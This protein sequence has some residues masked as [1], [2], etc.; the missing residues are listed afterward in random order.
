[1]RIPLLDF[2]PDGLAAASIVV[3]G[4]NRKGNEPRMA[5]RGLSRNQKRRRTTV[6]RK[7]AKTQMTEGIFPLVLASLRLCVRPLRRRV[8]QQSRQRQT[9]RTKIFAGRKEMDRQ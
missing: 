1:M 4:P 9:F 8:E 3:A 5:Q 7:G 2:H 6:S